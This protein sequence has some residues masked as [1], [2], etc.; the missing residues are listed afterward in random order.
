M[1]RS[2]P[3]PMV[4]LIRDG[5]H[6]AN[7]RREGQRAVWSALFRTAASASQ[8]GWDRWEWE[9]LLQE[10]TSVLGRQAS[11]R[12]G[13]RPRTKEATAKTLGDAWDRATI[14]ASEQPPQWRRE[15]AVE[16]ALRRADLL[17]ELAADPDADLRD[18]ERAVLAHAAARGRALSSDRPALPRAQMLEATG[19]GLTALRGALDRLDDAE[20]LVLAERGRS[21]PHGGRA[22]LYRLAREGHPALASYLYRETRSVVPP[23]QVCS[24]PPVKHDGAPPQVC[25]APAPTPEESPM[26]T[27]TLTAPDADAL[28][29]ALAALRREH[30]VVMVNTSMPTTVNASM[31]DNVRPMRRQDRA[32]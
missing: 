26:V 25:S 5:A 12:D 14:W 1:N 30:E 20:L 16:Q 28:A 10:P 27:L 21:S 32:S 2:L 17:A 9:L 6:P 7:L 19:L 31:P 18:T 8:R 3:A 29:A 15:Q 4:D 23:G 13:R 22:N 11:T 24:A